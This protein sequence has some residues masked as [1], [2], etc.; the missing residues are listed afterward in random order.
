VYRWA[1]S[2]IGEL[3]E[4]RINTADTDSERFRAGASVG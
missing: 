1:G 2:L 3:C 4:M